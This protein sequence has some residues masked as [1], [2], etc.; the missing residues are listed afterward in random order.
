MSRERDLVFEA[1]RRGI[2][3][4]IVIAEE[5][6]VKLGRVHTE[7]GRL[8]DMRKVRRN[9]L[10]W[11]LMPPALPISGKARVVRLMS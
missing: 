7:L 1:V 4:P 9:G 2:A 8:K 3:S 10:L 11:E 5:T 6:G